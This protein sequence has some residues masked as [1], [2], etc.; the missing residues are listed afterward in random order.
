MEEEEERRQQ[1]VAEVRLKRAKSETIV[2]ERE[3]ALHQVYTY[4][5]THTHTILPMYCF[6]CIAEAIILKLLRG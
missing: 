5:H 3:S 6:Y 4:T 1:M 2:R